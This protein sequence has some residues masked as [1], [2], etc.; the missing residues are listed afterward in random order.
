MTVSRRRPEAD[1][2]STGDFDRMVLAPFAQGLFGGFRFEGVPAIEGLCSGQQG[3]KPLVGAALAEDV[4][5]LI[6]V[7]RQ[8]LACKI[9]RQRL[10]ETEFPLA[11]KCTFPDWGS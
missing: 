4:S 1:P 3:S 7:I 6:E 9:Q 11:G 10:A 2:A 8:K 5:E